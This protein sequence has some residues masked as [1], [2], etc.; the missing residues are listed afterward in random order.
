[1]QDAKASLSWGSSLD[2][3]KSISLGSVICSCKMLMACETQERD[4]R[5]VLMREQRASAW[6]HLFLPERDGLTVLSAICKAGC[7]SW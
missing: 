7:L 5:R 1:M 4:V 3:V 2:K 6:R